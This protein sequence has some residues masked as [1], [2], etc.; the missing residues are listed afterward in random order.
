MLFL[1]FSCEWIEMPTSSDYEEK[2]VI[3][4][5]L[6]ANQKLMEYEGDFGDESLDMSFIKLNRT[7]DITEVYSSDTTT[8]S[9][10]FVTLE[11][12]TIDSLYTLTESDSLPGVYY[13]SELVFEEGHTYRITVIDTLSGG[14]VDTVYAET[15]I[16][17]ALEITE[18]IVDDENIGDL[19]FKDIVYKPAV[20]GQASM[21]EPI[22]FTLKIKSLDEDYPPAMGRIINMAVDEKLDDYLEYYENE[23]NPPVELE[24]DIRENLMITEDDTLL[25]FLWKWHHL[26]EDSLMQ[27]ILLRR[28]SQWSFS[29]LED[30]LMIGWTFLTFYGPQFLGI[31]ALDENY[32]NYHKGNLEGPP[33]DPHYLP[34]SNIIGGYGLFASGNLG[35]ISPS[36]FPENT[37]IYYLLKPEQNK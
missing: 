30:D 11:D 9:N 2:I 19:M 15:T 25:A 18:T 23:E 33:S 5:M 12:L 28:T 10:D 7:A 17:S 32:L 20:S 4:G 8:I 1:A 34:E 13:H 14:F 16:P 26:P 3:N 22:Q 35:E 21:F 27:R 24:Q 29:Q 37:K 36:G 31:Y 6:F